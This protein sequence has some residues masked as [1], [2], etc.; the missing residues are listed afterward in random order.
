MIRRRTG[1][2]RVRANT[3]DVTGLLTIIAD[4]R[5]AYSIDVVVVVCSIH[6]VGVLYWG[7]RSSR[8]QVRMSRDSLVLRAAA[9]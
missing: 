1:N 3:S 2:R 7:C 8:S 4:G 5:W 9:C 6:H